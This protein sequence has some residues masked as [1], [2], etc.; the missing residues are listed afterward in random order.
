MF[1]IDLFV[2]LTNCGNLAHCIYYQ[3]H[4]NKFLNV[5]VFTTKH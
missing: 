5:L 1:Y 3:L 4:L 2:T